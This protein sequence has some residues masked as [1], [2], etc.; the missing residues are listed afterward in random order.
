[1]LNEAF[2]T[3]LQ[4][5]S[6]S[7]YLLVRELVLADPGY[8]YH[9]RGLAQLQ[10]LVTQHDHA[11]LQEQIRSMM[12]NWQLS[13]SVHFLASYAAAQRQEE[14]LAD[15]ERY[16]GQACLQCLLESGRGTCRCPY[17]ITHPSDIEDILCALHQRSQEQLLIPHGS[18]YLCCVRCEDDSEIWFDVTPGFAGADS[19]PSIFR[20]DPLP[21]PDNRDQPLD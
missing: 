14:E 8:L 4:D 3:F 9:C 7:N 10:K 5:P 11:G 6:V 20:D 16:I 2:L 21:A 13:P 15:L 18:R 1:M 19:D 17:Q 12:P